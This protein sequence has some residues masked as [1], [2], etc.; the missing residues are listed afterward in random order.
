M[1]FCKQFCAVDRSTEL[2]GCAM[3]VTHQYLHP[4]DPYE[5]VQGGTLVRAQFEALHLC[6]HK[7]RSPLGRKRQPSDSTLSSTCKSASHAVPRRMQLTYHAT[8]RTSHT[9][10]RAWCKKWL[11]GRCN[12]DV[13]RPGTVGMRGFMAMSTIRLRSC[14]T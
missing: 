4:C 13:P 8:H 6:A 7:H 5:S 1:F 2:D 14:M 12:P 3:I 9:A 11:P 10:L